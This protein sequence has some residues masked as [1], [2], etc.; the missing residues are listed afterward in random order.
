MQAIIL[1]AGMGKRLGEYTKNNT[2]CMVEVNGIKLIDRV[3]TQLAHLQLKR[4]VIVIGYKGQ[5]LKEYIGHRYDNVL[6]IE[7]IENSVY[8]QTNNIYSLALAKGELCEDDTILLESDII[9]EDS[10][11]QKLINDPYPDL[12]L[13]DKY[14]SWMDGTMVTINDNNE[15]ENFINKSSFKFKEISSYYKTVNLY[16]FSKEFSKDVYVPFLETYCNVMGNNQYYEEVL[17]VLTA[18]H[19]SSLHALPLQGDKWYEIDDIQDLDIA[20]TIF[21][22]DADK[23]YMYH[24]RYGGFWRFPQLLDFCYLVNPYFPNQKMIEEL[25]SNFETLLR[26]YPSGMYVNSLLAARYFSIKQEFVAV[27][28]GAAELIK[29]VMEE[30]TGKRVGVIFP[31][32]DEY[33]NRLNEKQIVSFV[34]K[35]DDFSY[36][37]DDLIAFFGDKNISL[38]LLINP[39]NPSGHFINKTDLLKLISWCSER[40]IQIIVDESFVDFTD[41]SENNS[42]LSNDILMRFHNLMVMKSISK[43][44]GVPGLRLGILASANTALINHIK[45]E[46]SIWNVNSFAEYYM[47]VFGK[48]ET[49]YKK[50]CRLFVH[51]R[52]LFYNELKDISYLHVIPSQANFFLC[53][54]TDKYSSAEL[55]NELI[56]KDILISNCSTKRCMKGTGK[57]LIRLAIRDR[58]DDTKLINVLKSLE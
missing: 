46:V 17:R 26:E 15:I 49:E 32:F 57:Q 45:K 34:S 24:R 43:S 33:P 40:N 3:I 36:T 48:Y 47:Q 1:A 28:N 14:Q 29:N 39:D 52:E 31:T 19:Q 11:L 50:A 21:S 37:I 27:G 53:E 56:R 41:K 8:D 55:A 18:I 44:Y 54:V 35:K 5:E 2:K 30:H 12:A 51:E 13:V 20:S 10:V 22:C 38:L 9:F 4:L 6:K 25:K 23:F 16:K 58:K 42:L 7:Y